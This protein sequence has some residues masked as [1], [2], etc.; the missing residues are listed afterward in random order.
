MG[1]S[2][3]EPIRRGGGGGGRE[4]FGMSS[5]SRAFNVSCNLSAQRIMVNTS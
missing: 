5:D 3:R 4:K 1:L 2:A